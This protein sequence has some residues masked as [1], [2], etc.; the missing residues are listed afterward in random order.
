MKWLQA[1]RSGGRAIGL[2]PTLMIVALVASGC[3]KMTGGGWIQS[4]SLDEGE[5]ATFGFT[6]QCKNTTTTVAGI[7]VPTAVLHGGQF[8]FEDHGLG[9]SVH[10][11]VERLPLQEFPSRTCKDLRSEPNLL[12]TGIFGGT[13]RTQ[14]GMTPAHNGEFVVQVFDGGKPPRVDAGAG[15]VVA[16]SICIELAGVA[17]SY[18]N[19]GDLQGGS[20]K[21]E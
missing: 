16:D 21:V 9:V 14:P 7:D 11:T 5:K 13:Y 10:G 8:E 2:I 15:T 1:I 3:T 19:C 12:G 20:I 17:W 6:A 4:S 18:S